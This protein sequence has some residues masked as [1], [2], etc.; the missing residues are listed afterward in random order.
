VAGF[1]DAL[2]K[3]TN[4]PKI[5]DAQVYE[6]II[7]RGIFSY[8]TCTSKRLHVFAGTGELRRWSRIAEQ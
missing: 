6:N 5:E 4:T 8:I 2:L 3:N 7:R 1:A